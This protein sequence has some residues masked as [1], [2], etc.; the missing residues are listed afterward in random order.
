MTAAAIA[1]T[2][3]TLD[4]LRPETTRADALR[5]LR[6]VFEGAGLDT[7]ALDA[8]ILLTEAL[9]I[10]EVELLTSPDSGL[11][12][13]GASGLREL[14]ARRL[15]REPVARI[16]GRRE[17]WGLSFAL[18]PETLVPRPDTETVVELALTLVAD[19]SRPWRLLD[20]GTGSGC[21]L[22]ALLHELPNATG[23]GVDRSPGALRIARANAVRNGVGSRAHFAA[24]DWGAAAR[25]RFDLV[26]SNPPY[27]ASGIV[28]TLAPEVSRHD[29]RPALDG[30]PD[31]LAAYRAILGKAPDLL[32]PRGRLV[33]E[34]GFDQKDAVAGL[35]RAAGL[36][37][38]SAAADLAG[39][40]RALALRVAAGT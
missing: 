36:A 11:G 32:D 31:G 8:R 39:R 10:G 5:V 20:L 7:T 15:A 34:I 29:P 25:G 27:I 23:L 26:V 6:T 22:V 9:A 21:L 1:R 19:R 13:E 2:S 24:S 18:G 4:L 30:G 28:E 16:L 17:F 14:A 12:A 33:L 37:V 38:E 3:P 35:A 40:S